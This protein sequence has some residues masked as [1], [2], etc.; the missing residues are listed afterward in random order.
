MHGLW[1]LHGCGMLCGVVMCGQADGCWILCGVVM[2][3]R[4][5]VPAWLLAAVWSGSSSKT[6][7]VTAPTILYVREFRPI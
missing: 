6:A 7:P 5:V 2:R 4:A 1:C 3:G